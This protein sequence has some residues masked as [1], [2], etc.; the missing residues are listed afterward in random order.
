MNAPISALKIEQKTLSI[1]KSLLAPSAIGKFVLTAPARLNRFAV[2]Q[3]ANF[4]LRDNLTQGDFDFLDNRLLKIVI[5]DADLQIGLTTS[6]QKIRCTFFRKVDKEAADATLSIDTS[7]AIK[8]IQ[9]KVD[10]DTLFFQRKLKI[11]GDTELAHHV[12]NTIDNL[13]PD[14]LP[15]I[16]TSLLA[17]YDSKVLG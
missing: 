14:L 6:Q 10:P 2:E 13:S 4:A 15:D 5:L 17:K 1:L 3:A 9:Q 16:L 11:S 7:N 8:L 12:K